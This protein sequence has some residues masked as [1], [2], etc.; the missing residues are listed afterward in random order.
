M[1]GSV[2]PMLSQAW[3]CSSLEAGLKRVVSH[4]GHLRTDDLT[5]TEMKD[6]LA[7]PGLF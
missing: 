2:K 1:A 5:E 3:S 6:E 4:Y 7:V